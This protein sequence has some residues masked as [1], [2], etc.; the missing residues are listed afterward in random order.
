M[1]SQYIRSILAL[2]DHIYVVDEVDDHFFI[3]AKQSV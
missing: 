1:A 3:L 2:E